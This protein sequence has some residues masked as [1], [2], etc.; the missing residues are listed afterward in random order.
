[1]PTIKYHYNPKTFQYERARLSVRDVLWYISG[2]LFTGLIL[3]GGMVAVHDS[4]V[5]T[6]TERAL[7]LE[8]KL[9][10]KH[11]PILEQQLAA[12]DLTLLG[13]KEEDKLLYAKLFNSNPP[14]SSSPP[15]TISKEQALLADASSFR[16]L[17]DVLRSESE[18]LTEKS[19]MSN[20]SFGNQIRITKDQLDVIGSIPSIQPIA[21][22]QLDL[23]VS[24]FGERI[25]P[26]HKGR[27]H[28]PGVDFAAP[29][30]TAVT[31]TA[32]GR[33]IAVNRTTLQAGYGNFIDVDHGNGFVTRYAHLEEINVRRWQNI[34]KGMVIGTVGS[35]G[36]SVAPHL[37]YEVIRDGDPVDPAHYLMEG[38]TSEQH[39]VLLKLS[40]KQN[41]SMD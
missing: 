18:R 39:S 40:I 26:F 38:L 9:L 11:K 1:M 34:V 41:Q 12:I 17:L 30:G 21:N 10:Q 32:S 27:Y 20:A 7:R 22:V 37:H 23:L 16:T 13:L 8:N 35:S 3:C 33:V 31:V 36:G 2:L 4:L 28:H 24:G 19:T 6:E 5:E 29:R 25:N 14:E 15:S